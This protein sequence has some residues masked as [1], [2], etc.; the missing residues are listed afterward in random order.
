MIKLY[1]DSH[2]LSPYGFSCFVALRE[3]EIPFDYVAV[4]LPDKEQQRPEFRD[5]GITGR[6]PALE[7]D[8]FWLAESSAIIEY[9]EDTFAPPKHPRV[10]PTDPRQRARARQ[11]M[12][13]VRSDLMALS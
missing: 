9:L 4:S 12:A 2:W 7:H 1:S 8:D 11:V 5:R 13:W 3:K 10:L 6:V